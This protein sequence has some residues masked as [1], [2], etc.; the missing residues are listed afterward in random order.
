MIKKKPGFLCVS[1]TYQVQEGPPHR[2]PVPVG[3][4][5]GTPAP[6]HEPV[7]R[8]CWA[9]P[10][11]G[12]YAVLYG[13]S[14]VPP[15]KIWSAGAAAGVWGAGPTHSGPLRGPV[16]AYPFPS[17]QNL[18]PRGGVQRR[19]FTAAAAGGGEACS[20]LGRCLLAAASAALLLR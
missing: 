2:G 14:P 18:D 8:L 17:V 7:K 4:L 13:R 5:W 15:S 12:R 10:I 16:W 11:Q 9:Q 6:A 20:D 1:G 3:V 19:S